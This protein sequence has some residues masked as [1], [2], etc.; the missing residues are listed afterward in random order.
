MADL[1]FTFEE[2]I[3]KSIDMKRGEAIK[4]LAAIGSFAIFPGIRILEN[5]LKRNLHFV[6]FGSGG[7]NAMAFICKQGIK[8]NY[9]CITGSYITHL[10][11]DIKHIFRETPIEY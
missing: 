8:A 4:C 2:I 3:F 11:P 5:S 1:D 9:Y 7:T 6:A 10:T